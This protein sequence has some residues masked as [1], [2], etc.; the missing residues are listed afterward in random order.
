MS[1]ST[2]IGQAK[3][4]RVLIVGV[5]GLGCPAA[6]ALSRAGVGT[7]VLCDDDPIEASNLHRQILFRQEHVGRDKIT[8]AK[9]TLLRRGRTPE[10]VQLVRS[11]FLPEN[12]RELAR[13]VD[14]V[15][16]GAD[17]FATKFLA[18][19]AC[20]LEKKPIVHGAA[21]RW[22]AT[23]WLVGP[24]GRPCYRCL[25][26]DLPARAASA[27]CNEAGVMGPVVGFAGALMAD[28]A[29]RWLSGDHAA[30]GRVHTFDGKSDTLRSVGVPARATCP[31]CGSEQS[32]HDVEESRYSAA[33]CAA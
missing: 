26:E 8:V 6:L 28:L 12:A 1:F 18:A 11:R 5:G 2:D 30:A 3:T 22:Q 31:L 19:D 25:F 13:S 27:T 17:N 20:R 32:I 4:A 29:L 24:D 9:E 21:I 15:V 7:L 14:L 10:G 16:E 23:M 33:H